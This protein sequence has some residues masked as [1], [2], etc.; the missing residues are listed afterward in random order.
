MWTRTTV[1]A[2]TVDGSSSNVTV[3]ESFFDARYY[4]SERTLRR[5]ETDRHGALPDT[6][7]SESGVTLACWG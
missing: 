5:A 1:D 7:L 3:R 4:V 6:D 2:G